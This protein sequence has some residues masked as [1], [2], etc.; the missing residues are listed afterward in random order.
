ME[1]ELLEK[2]NPD[3]FKLPTTDMEV[4]ELF[5]SYQEHLTQ[6]KMKCSYFESRITGISILE[7]LKIATD[8]HIKEAKENKNLK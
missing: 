5:D 8:K 6:V 3:E 4:M 1:S 7:S 2:E